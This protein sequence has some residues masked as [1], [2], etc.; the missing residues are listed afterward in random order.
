MGILF[1][2]FSSDGAKFSKDVHQLALILRDLKKD[3]VP[4]DEDEIDALAYKIQFGKRKRVG[5]TSYQ[6]GDLVTIFHEAIGTFGMR[7]YGSNKGMLAILTNPY[8][9]TYLIR[10]KYT[11]IHINGRR[12]AYVLRNGV[13]KNANG[14]KVIGM[15]KGANAV[16]PEILIGDNNFGMLNSFS[17]R[18]G[19]QD[20]AVQMVKS[21]PEGLQ[22]LF[23]S[24]L[25]LYIVSKQSFLDPISEEDHA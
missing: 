22:E 9:Y 12:L 10:K 7:K 3:L 20:R 4:I 13:I 15:I 1:D 2:I 24:I 18:V 23:T 5:F 16:H 25:F 14:R 17:S 19:P 6:T 11:E 21:M 8:L